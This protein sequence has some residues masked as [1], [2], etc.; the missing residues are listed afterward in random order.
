[1]STHLRHATAAGALRFEGFS[2]RYPAAEQWAIEGID[3]TIDPGEFVLI[4]GDSGSGKSSFLRA[5]SGLVPHH[6]GGEAAG[7]ASIS[8]QDLRDASAGALAAVCGSLF[9]DPESQTVMDSVRAE[10][11]FPLENLG[12]EHAQIEIAVAET[13]QLLGVGGL[14][15]RRTDELSGGELQRVVLAAA[16]AARPA[17]LV[18][19]EPTSQLDP[20]AA[21]E[22]LGTLTRLAHDHGTTVLLADHRVDRALSHAD[23]VLLFDQGSVAIDAV[24]TDF[25]GAILRAPQ[26]RHLVPALAELFALAGIDALPLDVR[27]A[28]RELER[29]GVDPCGLTLDAPAA[30]SPESRAEPVLE[31]GSLGYRYPRAG[32]EALNEV[33]LTIRRGERVVLLGGNGAGKSTL[34]QLA[35]G[36]REPG[37]GSVDATGEV[38]LLLQNPND[39]LIHTR[40]ADEA[41]L[42]SL[43]RFGVDHLRDCDPR[44]LSGGQRQ[45]VALAI[46]MQR[47]PALLLLD[48]PSRGMGAGDKRSLAGLITEIARSGTAVLVATHDVEFAALF[49]E[50]AVLLGNGH[51]L[52]DAP[53]RE[54][55]GGGWHFS[56]STARLLAGSGAVTPA[57]GAGLITG[58]LGEGEPFG[59]GA[60]L[61]AGEGAV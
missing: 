36:L 53:A 29:L 44:D 46:V 38:A 35:Q 47:R 18:L 26:R 52:A 20:V 8:G 37:A 32:R 57:E 50:R 14:L 31:L 51:V 59:G 49:A 13:A 45:R 5:V 27:D 7:E 19:D 55:L 41:P 54:V 9:Q 10:I 23:R 25:L 24:P 1:M 12:W 60:P 58:A 3:L 17:V 34:L 43:E 40:V 22:L 6:F 21:D 30:A 28:R 11:A 61:A 2:Y 4:C 16:L 33:D 56:T 15:D 42:E 39:Y 48:E